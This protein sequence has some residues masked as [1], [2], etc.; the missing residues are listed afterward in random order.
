VSER[1]RNPR[2]K[3]PVSKKRLLSLAAVAI[4]IGV[5]LLTALNQFS[6][7]SETNLRMT[8]LGERIQEVEY[9]ETAEYPI[10]VKNEGD[11]SKNIHL[12]LTDVP[13]HWEASIDKEDLVLSG[14]SEEI[15]R[16]TV[17]APSEEIARTRGPARVANVGVRGGNVT[18][19]TI[20]ILKGTATV[21][22]D[23][24]SSTLSSDD[25]ILSGDE[26]TTVGFSRIDLD[27]SKLVNDS[28]NY[29]GKV[30]SVLLKDAKVSFVAR[31]DTVY[32]TV[33]NGNVTVL[34]KG[35][36]GG[37]SSRAP[38]ISPVINL[39]G[40]ALTDLGFSEEEY[41]MVLEFGSFDTDSFFH[42]D[43]TEEETTVEVFEGDLSVGNSR[44]TRS[45]KKY[46]QT[47][48]VRTTDVPEPEPVERT[49]ITLESSGSV[50]GVVESGGQNLLERDDVHYFPAG[51]QEFYIAPRLPEIS[52]DLRGMKDGDYEIDIAQIGDRTG[53]S[54]SVKSNVTIETRDGFS[55]SENSLKVE[56]ME[57]TKTYDLAVFYEDTETGET[58]D[59]EVVTIKSS[60]DEQAIVIE[61]WEKL[62]DDEAETVVFKEGETEV[63]I[64][65]GATGEEIEEQLE[66]EAGEEDDAEFE[67]SSV[68]PF[69]LL[70]LIL[71]VIV[72]VV[73][74]R[75][76][77]GPKRKPG[78]KRGKKDHLSF[79][80]RAGLAQFERE[81]PE[82]PAG[83][84]DEVKTEDVPLED[85][86]GPDEI[87]GRDRISDSEDGAEP[88][89]LM[90]SAVTPTEPEG[91][92]E[93]EELKAQEEEDDF[94][95]EQM[96]RLDGALEAEDEGELQGS[97]L[98]GLALT[99]PEGEGESEDEDFKVPRE[100]T[101]EG[102][103]ELRPSEELEFEGEGEGEDVKVPK[104]PEESAAEEEFRFPDD[105]EQ[106]ED[107]GFK[108]LEGPEGP[109]AEEEL[110]F[111]DDG[112]R[113]EDEGF[114][115][116]EEPEEP[117][118]E[119][120][121]RFSGDEERVEDEGFRFSEEEGL[122]G[123]EEI[124]VSEEPAEPE[125]EKEEFKIFSEEE[126]KLPSW[127]EAFSLLMEDTGEE[128]PGREKESRLFGGEIEFPEDEEIPEKEE[129][130]RVPVEER[131]SGLFAKMEEVSVLRAK[132]AEMESEI[133]QSPFADEEW[134][135]N[136]DR[137]ID[138]AL[139]TKKQEE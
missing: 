56:K 80:E 53:K 45:L 26:I 104:E 39:S 62:E 37:R 131:L 117:A 27:Y 81:E 19:G 44:S 7:L 51:A 23:G 98:P 133:K 134:W 24:V 125:G 60:D 103:E 88:Q 130:P 85:T 65:N 82:G 64:T 5:V 99:G 92:G 41:N 58:A 29:T 40:E 16:L 119:D 97:T 115:F 68:L 30:I 25:D 61:D 2:T 6:I 127:K 12:F 94:F 4:L 91:E 118:A 102:E 83:P 42:L 109:V 128:E 69:V 77:E 121:F 18:I 101:D 100:P 36:G 3:T 137:K 138:N 114:K 136:W 1:I 75:K 52:V 122:V 139:R 48:A 50:E 96:R 28:T 17:T 86:I 33:A 107:E 32:M 8:L 49:I 57:E 63:T 116:P 46:E 14:K 38:S 78:K 108:F 59:F 35:G 105:G 73:F 21:T 10:Y 43:V 47:T 74:S 54:F 11:E 87:G 89:G 123:D 15:V 71:V 120:D 20:T 111:P 55:Y 129:E 34:V 95:K 67:W 66:E 106:A 79:K 13:A 9:E 31:N 135:E 84:D 112:E 72:A 76:K 110:S 126:F 90:P 132:L 93:G 124:K 113:I 70:L 22:R